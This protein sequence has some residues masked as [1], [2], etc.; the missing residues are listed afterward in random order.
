[1]VPITLED[2]S[3]KVLKRRLGYVKGL[4]LRTSFF[5][6]TTSASTDSDYAR[7]LEMEIQEQKE[8]IHSQKEEI[9]T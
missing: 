2:L 6:R 7:R 4:G 5:V 8:E 3:M 9:T 1:M